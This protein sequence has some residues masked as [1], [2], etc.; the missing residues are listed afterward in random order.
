MI[1]IQTA[2]WRL[3]FYLSTAQLL[4]NLPAQLIWLRQL[5]HINMTTS[6]RVKIAEK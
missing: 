4:N 1:T 3:G 2:T 6:H 5:I